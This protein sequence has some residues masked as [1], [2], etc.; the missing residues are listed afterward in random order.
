[1]FVNCIYFG[2]YIQLYDYMNRTES[3]YN[4]PSLEEVD[5]VERCEDDTERCVF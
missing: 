1:M 4:P 3:N 2:Y 5:E